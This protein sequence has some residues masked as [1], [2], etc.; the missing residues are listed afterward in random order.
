MRA[1]AGPQHWALHHSVYIQLALSREGL[2]RPLSAWPESGVTQTFNFAKS[3][4]SRQS[5][6]QRGITTASY[7]ET[8][9]GPARPEADG[10]CVECPRKQS[11]LKDYGSSLSERDD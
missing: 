10:Y 9:A 3:V 6:H 4:I 2:M 11:R 1:V 7:Q 8:F 5:F